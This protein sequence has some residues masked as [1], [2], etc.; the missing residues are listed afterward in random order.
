MCAF[1]V[2]KIV[3]NVQIYI[4]GVGVKC[5]NNDVKA[6]GCRTSSGFILI[7]NHWDTYST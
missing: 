1:H 4:G 3:L 6:H 7:S 5:E 2:I